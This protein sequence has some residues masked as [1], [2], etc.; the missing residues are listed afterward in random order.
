MAKKTF[1]ISRI[2]IPLDLSENS[3]LAL[4][5]GTFMAKL[6]KAEL[7]LVHIMET[8]VLR[9]DLGSITT[10]EKKSATEAVQTKLDE[11]ASQV[12]LKHGIKTRTIIKAGKISKSI[13]DAA[14][15]NK[16]DIIVMG[17]HGVSGF[18]EFFIGSNAF[19]VVTESTC[20]VLTV[21]THTSKMGFEKILLPID[22]SDESREKVPYAMRL[23]KAYNARIHILGILSV[24]DD[25]AAALLDKKLEQVEKYMEK[26]EIDYTSELVEGDNLA[27]T[28]LKY[29]K[30]SKA[31]LICIMTEQEENFTGIFIGPYAQ[32][33]VNHSKIPVISIR[34]EVE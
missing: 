21:Q 22:S 29:A 30:K 1:K 6:F 27:T 17:T 5:H 19:R 3:M 9:L 32:Q 23:A 14:T 26:H 4:E 16:I 24:D 12:Y 15:E 28:T 10:A 20:P 13:V 2:L 33:V 11:L 8:R 31:D 34:P 7:F 18:E 25:D